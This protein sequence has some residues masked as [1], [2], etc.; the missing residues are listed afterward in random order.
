MFKNL[1]ITKIRVD[2]T[3]SVIYIGL[4]KEDIIFFKEFIEFVLIAITHIT[5]RNKSIGI[6]NSCKIKDGSHT[7]TI[8]YVCF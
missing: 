4:Y 1:F 7:R 8:S 3:V 5:T 2:H 6:Y